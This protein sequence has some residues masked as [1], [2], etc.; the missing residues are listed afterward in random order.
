MLVES[1]LTRLDDKVEAVREDVSELKSDLK[2]HIQETRQNMDVIRAHV[3][4][5]TR[6]VTAIEPLVKELPILVEIAKEYHW[7]K[8]AKEKKESALSVWTKRLAILASGAT[9]MAGLIKI[10]EMF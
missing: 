3:T 4:A 9:L 5:D 10:T 1:Q 6:I 2:L 7:Q 8:M